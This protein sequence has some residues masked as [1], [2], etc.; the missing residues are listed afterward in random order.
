M[1]PHLGASV[2]WRHPGISGLLPAIIQH[3]DDDD[4]C[5]ICVFGDAG[6]FMLNGVSEGD[7]PGT[8]VYAERLPE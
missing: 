4:R 2:L 6:P 7:G 1:K 8:W 5:R 3:V